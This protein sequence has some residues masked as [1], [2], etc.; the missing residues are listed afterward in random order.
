MNMKQTLAV[1]ALLVGIALP[2]AAQEDYGHKV[3]R[4]T[5]STGELVVTSNSTPDGESRI[6]TVQ[7]D[8][9]QVKQFQTEYSPTLHILAYYQGSEDYVVLRTNMGQGGCVPTDIYVIRIDENRKAT[10][11]P[12]LSECAGETPEIRFSTDHKGHSSVTVQG[13]RWNGGRWLKA[14]VGRRQT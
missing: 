8:G 7:L 14:V 13:Q 2:S 6:F 4:V 11:S 10:V 1:L 3:V 12:K 5:I 9:R